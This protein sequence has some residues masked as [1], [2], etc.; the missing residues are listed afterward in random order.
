MVTQ[1]QDSVSA[2]LKTKTHHVANNVRCGL[3]DWTFGPLTLDLSRT[4]GLRHL[5]TLCLLRV[6]LVVDPWTLSPKQVFK[7][8]D[9][10]QCVSFNAFASFDVTLQLRKHFESVLL[11]CVLQV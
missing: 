5:N 1:S 8:F 7:R 9:C 10:D 4:L 2:R 11:V 6:L 3:Y